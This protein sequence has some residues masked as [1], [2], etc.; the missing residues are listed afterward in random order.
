MPST[1]PVR[2]VRP[3]GPACRPDLPIC[4]GLPWRCRS[5]RNSLFCL[6]LRLIAREFPTIGRL[7]PA[8]AV[9]ARKH[10][11]V[12]IRHV[13]LHGCDPARQ[14]GGTPNAFALSPPRVFARGGETMVAAPSD[15]GVSDSHRVCFGW[16]PVG[17]FDVRDRANPRGGR[18]PNWPPVGSCS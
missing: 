15:F 7:G 13:A 3:S 11:P 17:I 1:Y 5:S 10:F 6:C 2:I 4:N 12:N 14:L 8:S 16:P 18:P 9:L